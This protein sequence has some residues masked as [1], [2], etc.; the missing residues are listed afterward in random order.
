MWRRPSR[1]VVVG[2]RGIIHVGLCIV[3]LEKYVF[4]VPWPPVDSFIQ[5]HV[6]ASLLSVINYC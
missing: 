5:C 3:L 4:P 1:G 6:D 2:T